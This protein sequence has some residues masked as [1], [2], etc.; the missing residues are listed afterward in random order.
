MLAGVPGLR[1][2]AADAGRHQRNHSY[3]PILVG[4]DFALTRDELYEL[5]KDQGIHARRYFYPLISDF[6]MYR[7][8]PSAAPANLPVAARDRGPGAVPADL[9]GDDGR[10]HRPRGLGRARSRRAGPGRA[11]LAARRTGRPGAPRGS[12]ALSSR[13]P[14]PRATGQS[15]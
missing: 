9:P 3:F 13:A 12:G 8:L 1:M 15:S 7:G 11:G 14:T 2:L 6:P 4:P 5:L 10:R